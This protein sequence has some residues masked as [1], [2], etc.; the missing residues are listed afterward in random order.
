MEVLYI[1]DLKNGEDKNY[2][3]VVDISMFNAFGSG[4]DSVINLRDHPFNPWYNY[5]HLEP[6]S[7]ARKITQDHIKTGLAVVRASLNRS[8]RIDNYGHHLIQELIAVNIHV[9]S[10]SSSGWLEGA[11]YPFVRTDPV[12]CYSNSADYRPA[13]KRLTDFLVHYSQTPN[14]PPP[15]DF[16]AKMS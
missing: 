14:D 5:R 10:I 12:G 4:I 3:R 8:S 1:C 16:C 15:Y 2:A 6:Q 7:A 9:I 11:P 13:V